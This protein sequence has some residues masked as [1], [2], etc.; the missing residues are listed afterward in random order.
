[1][2]QPSDRSNQFSHRPGSSPEQ[3]QLALPDL[4]RQVEALATRLHQLQVGLHNLMELE[5][6][7]PSGRSDPHLS[8]LEVANLQRAVE[9]LERQIAH[10]WLDWQYWRE[11]FWQ[12][13]RYGGL[14]LI[15]GWGLAWL[16]YRS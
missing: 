9:E 5:Q 1:M 16:V 8:Q 12:A 2:I 14:G 4:L 15:I 6:I 11:P 13:L 3:P 7:S 10:H